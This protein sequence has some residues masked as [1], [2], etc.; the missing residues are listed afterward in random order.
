MDGAL[1][2]HSPNLL[3]VNLRGNI[4]INESFDHNRIVVLS[5]NISKKCGTI[6]EHL[7]KHFLDQCR[8][9]A[10]K[11]END[12]S[13]CKSIPETTSEGNTLK[14]LFDRLEVLTHGQTTQNELLRKF[15]Q[16]EK[17]KDTQIQT[18]NEKLQNAENEIMQLKKQIEDSKKLA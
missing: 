8:N 18:T 11:P 9:E 15:I 5:D 17:N 3:L 2:A 14:N 12:L 10:L 7:L 4:C 13:S 1:F 16:D 6:D